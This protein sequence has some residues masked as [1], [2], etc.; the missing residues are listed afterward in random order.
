MWLQVVAFV[1]EAFFAEMDLEESGNSE[2]GGKVG[3]CDEFF[4]LEHEKE[5]HEQFL[6]D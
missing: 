6:I 1:L 4:I 5:L 3:A 2:E